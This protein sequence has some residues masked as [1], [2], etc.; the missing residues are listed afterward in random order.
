MARPTSQT[1]AMATKKEMLS[2]R[3]EEVESPPESPT[4]EYADWLRYNKKYASNSKVLVE[5]DKKGVASS[6]ASSISTLSDHDSVQIQDDNGDFEKQL[7]RYP[8]RPMGLE[9]NQTGRS[10]ATN[11]TTD[12]AFEVD[13]EEDDKQN[14]QNWPIWRKAFT[15]F[16]LSWSTMTV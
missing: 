12:P 15:L 7:S 9:R 10:V 4:G 5:D 14:A 2:P 8:S 1:D 6:R 11:M 13:F 3:A 16:C